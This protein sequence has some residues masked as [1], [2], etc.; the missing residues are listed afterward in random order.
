MRTVWTLAL[1]RDYASG[2]SEPLALW[3]SLILPSC[4]YLYFFLTRPKEN[5]DGFYFIGSV[6]EYFKLLGANSIF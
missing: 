4:F 3:Q 5:Y 1:V 6:N 2:T